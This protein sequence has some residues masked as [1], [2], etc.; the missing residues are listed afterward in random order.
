MI[1]F[2]SPDVKLAII[3]S[4]INWSLNFTFNTLPEVEKTCKYRIRCIEFHTEGNACF[5]FFGCFTLEQIRQ[6]KIFLYFIGINN[7]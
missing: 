3:P 7:F 6:I 4:K 5:F 2:L 1:K